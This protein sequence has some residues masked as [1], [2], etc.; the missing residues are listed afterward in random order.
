[1]DVYSIVMLS[2]LMPLSHVAL[3]RPYKLEIHIP[4]FPSNPTKAQSSD[5]K[6]MFAQLVVKTLSVY[7]QVMKTLSVYLQAPGHNHYMYCL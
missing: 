6:S 7:L 5:N 1:M 3:N 4:H 2:S